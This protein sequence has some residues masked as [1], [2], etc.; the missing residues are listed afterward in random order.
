MKHFRC[1]LEYLVQTKHF[2]C[3]SSSNGNWLLCLCRYG[4]N[5]IPWLLLLPYRGCIPVANGDWNPPVLRTQ[6]EPSS[7]T[8]YVRPFAATA[9]VC[10]WTGPAARRGVQSPGWIRPIRSASAARILGALPRGIPS[11]PPGTA[12]RTLSPTAARTC[13][14]IPAARQRTQVYRFSVV[15]TY[16]C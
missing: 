3:F 8:I 14:S 5:G 15:A 13:S 2:L 9:R 7:E 11:V 1:W 10:Q 16:P 12:A 6:T 4:Q